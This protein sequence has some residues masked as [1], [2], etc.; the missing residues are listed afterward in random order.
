MIENARVIA[1]K[2]RTDEMLWINVLAMH[3]NTCALVI[4]QKILAFLSSNFILSL[5]VK[6]V[7]KFFLIACQIKLRADVHVFCC[8]IH[9]LIYNQNCELSTV[10]I[11]KFKW[12]P[13]LIKRVVW[14]LP[15]YMPQLLAGV[16]LSNMRFPWCSLNH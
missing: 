16:R 6:L 14:T 3:D 8:E 5:L 11:W 15:E 1:S 7:S 4:S 13:V 2:I 9:V 10:S 12:M